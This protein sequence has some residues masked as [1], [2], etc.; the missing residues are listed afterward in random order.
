MLCSSRSAQVNAHRHASLDESG[1]GIMLWPH[2]HNPIYEIYNRIF[3]CR[4][5]GWANLQSVHLNLPFCGDEEFGRLHA[6]IR[7]LLPILPALAASSPVADRR[8]AGFQDN[9]LDVYRNNSRRMPSITGEIIPEP[10]FTRSEYD[11]KIFQPMYQDIAPL[12]PDGGCSTN[13]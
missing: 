9:R 10:V 7:L 4:G 5:H 6:A 13:G 3:D 1:P 11:R 2:Q 8:F 12:D